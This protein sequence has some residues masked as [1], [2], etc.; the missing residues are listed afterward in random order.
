MTTYVPYIQ[1]LIDGGTST[2]DIKAA[3]ADRFDVD[4]FIDYIVIGNVVGNTDAWDNNGQIVTWGKLS[5]SSNLNWSVSVYDCDLTF[6][7][8]W[9]GLY[10]TAADSSKLGSNYPLYK[11]FWSY[12][13]DELKARYQE[14]RDKGIFDAEH[15]TGLFRDWMDR[16]G[17]DNYKK[18]F[19][20][21]P[22]SPC[23]RNGSQTY[24]LYPT[25]GG[26]YGSIERIYL[27]IKK[28][29]EYMDAASFFDYNR[30]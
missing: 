9:D 14:L 20:K 15:I 1:G 26:M 7:C 24:T 5:G 25:T 28:R 16:V 2:A 30:N 18:E 3:I 8:R 10:A 17:Y 29:I 6:G 4:S 11:F 23:F 22:E 27:W 13:Y 21:W 12:Y 19:T